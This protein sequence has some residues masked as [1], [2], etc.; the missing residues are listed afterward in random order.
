MT[1]QFIHDGA[2]HLKCLKTMVPI[3]FQA[4]LNTLVLVMH[5]LLKV[6]N[7]DEILAKIAWNCILSKNFN[8]ESV[9]ADLTMREINRAKS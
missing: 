7:T 8:P 9:F 4:L 6:S 3:Q 2:Q 5:V 1:L